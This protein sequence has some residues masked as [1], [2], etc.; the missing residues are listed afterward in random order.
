MANDE[1]RRRRLKGIA[2][3]KEEDANFR[4]EARKLLNAESHR[5]ANG[6]ERT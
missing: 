1:K 5:R 4:R 3:G 6:G 2:G